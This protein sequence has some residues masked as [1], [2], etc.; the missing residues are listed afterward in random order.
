MTNYF[1]SKPT[2][3]ALGILGSRKKLWQSG[4]ESLHIKD[5]YR[6]NAWASVTIDG[7]TLPGNADTFAKVYGRG[8]DNP[9]PP[10]SLESVSVEYVGELGM[11]IHVTVTFTCYT[12]GQFAYYEKKWLRP[13]KK[14]TVKFGYVKPFNES[15]QKGITLSNLVVAWYS[16]NTD[17]KAHYI[18]TVKLVGAARLAQS[19]EIKGGLKDR[20]KFKYKTKGILGGTQEHEV[21]SLDEL[22][23]YD[24]QE[25]GKTPTDDLEDAHLVKTQWGEIVVYEPPQKAGVAGGFQR[26]AGKIWGEIANAGDKM[27]TYHNEYYTLGYV[28]DRLINDQILGFFKQNVSGTDQAIIGN[29]KFVCNTAT[30]IGHGYPLVRSA[31]PGAMLILGGGRGKYVNDSTGMGK[32]WEDGGGASIKCH[33]GNTV[34]LSKIMLE[35]T[36]ITQAIAHARAESEVS[37]KAAKTKPNEKTD[38]LIYA[39]AFLSELFKTIAYNTGNLFQLEIIEDQTDSKHEKLL[40]VDRNYGV[41]PSIPVFLFNPIDGDGSTREMTMSSEAGS[42][43]Y[44]Q[45]MFDSVTKASDINST[46]KGTISDADSKRA[47]KMNTV[48]SSI[49]KKVTKTLPDSGFATDEVEGLRSLLVEYNQVQPSK[50]NK[51]KQNII[52]PG[53]KMAVSLDGVY[54]FHVGNYIHTTLCPSDPYRKGDM[55]FWVSH[56]RHTIQNNDWQTDLD[57]ILGYISPIE[58]V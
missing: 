51:T 10:A 7:E 35:R 20:G 3:G 21:T 56:V 27:W 17:S 45:A 34:D 14:G 31:D 16:F 38:T 18:G 30:S 11:A 55:A 32:N 42:K 26:V 52:Y 8:G 19:V 12:S 53:L 9:K 25:N 36:T 40:I 33:N 5:A 23:L 29:V 46:I 39:K 6:N 28:V 54:G 49:D 24:A 47:A 57:A 13:G 22:L 1:R 48:K 50:D 41:A 37:E 2:D 44:M 43:E 15:E 4:R 58:F